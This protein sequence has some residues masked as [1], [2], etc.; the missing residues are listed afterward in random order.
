MEVNV[1]LL[2]MTKLVVPSITFLILAFVSTGCMTIRGEDS[3][4]Q[5]QWPLLREGATKRTIVL[6]VSGNF[7][8]R[9]LSYRGPTRL[10]EIGEFKEPAVK[11]YSD[12]GLFETIDALQR[13]ADVRADVT[14]AR[15]GNNGTLA[16]LSTILSGLTLTLIPGY[17]SQVF[18]I[19]TIYR[20]QS[21][22]VLGSVKKKESVSTWFQVFLLFPMLLGLVDSQGVSMWNLH[23]ALH[24]AT[25]EE[26]HT[27]GIL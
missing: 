16:I 6:N 15:E 14:I 5:N 10:V 20:D 3:R 9:T 25:I 26:A 24:R 13:K 18:T 2:T 27:A 17:D 23:Y 21:D 7:I 8:A 19:E 11:A 4:M 1:T 22:T 12:S